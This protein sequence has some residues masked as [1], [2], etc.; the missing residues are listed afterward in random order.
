MEA[1]KGAVRNVQICEKARGEASLA[2]A[3]AQAARIPRRGD[4]LNEPIR[5]QRGHIR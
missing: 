4:R 1:R 5:K 3:T 2:R